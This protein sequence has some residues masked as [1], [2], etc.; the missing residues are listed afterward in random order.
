MSFFDAAPETHWSEAARALFLMYWLVPGSA[1]ALI[2]VI[3]MASRESERPRWQTFVA[4]A[5][6][7]FAFGP[8]VV[9]GGIFGLLMLAEWGWYVPVSV[10]AAA[11]G[12][13]AVAARRRGLFDTWPEPREGRARARPRRVGVCFVGERHPRPRRAAS[14]MTEALDAGDVDRGVVLQPARAHLPA[15]AAGAT[16]ALA[17][18]TRRAI[19]ASPLLTRA[20]R[21]KQPDSTPDNHH[22]VLRIAVFG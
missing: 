6:L 16:T 9:F 2:A 12:A 3:A 1:F 7:T 20:R 5:A 15:A 17:L 11:A 18:R 8:V 19:G 13:W 4:V 14:I 21:R 10:L 22:S